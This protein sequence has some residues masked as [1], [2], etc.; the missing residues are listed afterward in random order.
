MS[1]IERAAPAD[2]ADILAL[3]ERCGLP[4]AGLEEALATTVVARE[5]GRMVGCSALEVYGTTALLRSVAVDPLRRSHGLGS[6]LVQR[7]LSMARQLRVHEVYL[8]T[9]TAA[10]YFPRFG[11]HQI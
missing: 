1:V 6:R 11:F 8:L 9:E 5:A 3:L 10:D 7:A 2:L 4:Q